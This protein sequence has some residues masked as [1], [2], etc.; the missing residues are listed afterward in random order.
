MGWVQLRDGE[1][2]ARWGAEPGRWSPPFPQNWGRQPLEGQSH[3]T[4]RQFC[5]PL[6]SDY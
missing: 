5:L 4:G 2:M 1:L 6:G 3:E